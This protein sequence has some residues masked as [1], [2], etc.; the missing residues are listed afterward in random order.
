MR[1]Y[2]VL[3]LAVPCSKAMPH[4]GFSL[5]ELMTDNEPLRTAHVVPY[6][7]LRAFQR[8]ASPYGTLEQSGTPLVPVL[9]L[10]LRPVES[11]L[12]R[13]VTY[14]TSASLRLTV[15]EQS[16]TLRHGC[17]GIKWKLLSIPQARFRAR[18]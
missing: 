4:A 12:R 15:N 17:K 11:S 13:H 9:K 7:T 10:Y 5:L 2:V 8:G 14:P 16:E 6:E 1:C 18:R 3:C